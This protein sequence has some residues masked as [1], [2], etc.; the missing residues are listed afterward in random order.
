M[1]AYGLDAHRWLGSEV[2]T[3]KSER[4]RGIERQLK[5][6]LYRL[7]CEGNGNHS[8]LLEQLGLN[9]DPSARD[10]HIM[11][12]HAVALMGSVH[13]PSS[14]GLKDHPVQDS[15]PREI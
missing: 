11:S 12:L 15:I 3:E 7:F 10:Q 13:P 6:A 2:D 1:A 14:G 5:L 9:A 4:R 8:N